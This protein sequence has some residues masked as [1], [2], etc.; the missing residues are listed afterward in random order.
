MK[1]NVISLKGLE[2]TGEVAGFNVKTTSGEI[3][4]LDR[5]RPLV[6]VLKN[7]TAFILRNDG[8]R[9]PLKISSGFLEMSPENELNV[10]IN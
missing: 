8:E 3:T 6:T 5:H 1:L 7:G 4:I 10:L 9:F 2:F